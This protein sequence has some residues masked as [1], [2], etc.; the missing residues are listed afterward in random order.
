MSAA[1]SAVEAGRRH[2]RSE[3][4]HNPSRKRRK[5]VE[6]QPR[7]IGEFKVAVAGFILV[8]DW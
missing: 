8:E 4:E 2:C 1:G 3:D 5:I 6:F 7:M